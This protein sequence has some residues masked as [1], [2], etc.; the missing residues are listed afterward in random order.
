MTR[1]IGLR[2][3]TCTK[4]DWYYLVFYDVDRG[5]TSAEIDMIDSYC[6][7]NNLSF[8]I[9]ETKHGCHIV[10]LT[11]LDC[12][13]WA[14]IFSYLKEHFESYYSGNVIRLSRKENEVQKLLSINIQY[15]EVI[16]NL[17][18][19]YCDRF[20]LKKMPWIKETSKYLLVFEKYRS[21]KE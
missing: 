11:P 1:L 2:N 8:I 3:I 12:Q 18:N 17:Y 6:R 20:N 4:E 7:L 5:I 16:P 10:I 15:G 14:K 9:Y 13:K 21:V 19:L